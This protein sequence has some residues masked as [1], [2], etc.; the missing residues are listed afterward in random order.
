MRTGAPTDIARPCT[1]A[2]VD[3]ATTAPGNREVP[4]RTT[5]VG[6][7]PTR[8]G[9]RQS[10]RL[11]PP[12]ASSAVVVAARVGRRRL[13]PLQRHRHDLDANSPPE[14]ADEFTRDLVAIPGGGV[15]C[16]R[17]DV[18]VDEL[19]HSPLVELAA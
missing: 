3:T 18:R 7:G 13:V 12:E 19:R 6:S 10:P 14:V 16:V 5:V 17:N 8:R 15:A 1:A 11:V 9:T 2:S 4:A